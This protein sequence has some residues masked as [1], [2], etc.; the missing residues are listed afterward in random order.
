MHALQHQ[1]NST[2]NTATAQS[3]LAGPSPASPHAPANSPNE[4]DHGGKSSELIPKQVGASV[5]VVRDSP[6]KIQKETAEKRARPRGLRAESP[7]RAIRHHLC[8]SCDVRS[9]KFHNKHPLVAGCKPLLNYCG[10]CEDK[11][12]R[13]IITKRHHFCFGCGVVRSKA[14]QRRHA[15]TVEQPL[16]PQLLCKMQKGGSRGGEHS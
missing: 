11:I 13:G 16:L 8:S 10:P 9:E 14:F 5:A 3:G 4:N 7:G 12:D 6:E 2:L 1:L 15:A